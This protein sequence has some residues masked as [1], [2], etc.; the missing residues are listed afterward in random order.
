MSCAGSQCQRDWFQT[1]WTRFVNCV[2]VRHIPHIFL[3]SMFHP[4][5]TASLLRWP[6]ENVMFLRAHYTAL[7]GLQCYRSIHSGAVAC[8]GGSRYTS[9]ATKNFESIKT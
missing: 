4:F 3:K 2:R 6:Q 7:E 8:R 5:H 1:R 9:S